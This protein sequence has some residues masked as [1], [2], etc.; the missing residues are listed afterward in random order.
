M[1]DDLE[2][3]EPVGVGCRGSGSCAPG[4]RKHRDFTGHDLCWHHPDLWDPP[5]GT[6]RAGDC[7][8]ALGKIH[9]RLHSLQA[10]AG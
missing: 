5:P 3:M 4:I 6:H 7:R 8:S 10:I 2:I 9:A 1:D